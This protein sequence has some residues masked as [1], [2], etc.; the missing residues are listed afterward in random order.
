MITRGKD[1]GVDQLVRKME[2]HIRSCELQTI[3]YG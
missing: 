2:E 1:E 3:V